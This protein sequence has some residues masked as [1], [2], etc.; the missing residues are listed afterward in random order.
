M[1]NIMLPTVSSAPNFAVE[2]R[3]AFLKFHFSELSVLIKSLVESVNTLVVLVT[4]LLF[5]PLA[6]D[7]L[8]KECVNELAKQNKG[9]AAIAIVMQKRITCLEKKC[10]QTCLEDRS[11]NDNIVDNNDNDDRDFSVYN[12]TFNIIMH[13]WEDQPSE[14]KSSFDQTAK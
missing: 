4:K 10:E 5:T 7:V 2:S 14:I 8:I 9:L 1:S 13:L 3:L 12:N 6:M 11:D